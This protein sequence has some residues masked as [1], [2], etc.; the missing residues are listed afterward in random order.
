MEKLSVVI[1]TLNEERNIARCI[2]GVQQIADEVVVIDSNSTDATV[3]ICESLGARVIQQP[4]LGYTEQKNFA[5]EQA[6]FPFVFSIDADEVPDARL[7][8]SI[9]E[10]KDNPKANGYSM[11]RL[12]NYCGSWVR[13]CGWYPDRKLRI[14]YKDKGLWTGGALH[15]KYELNSKEES[16]LLKGDLLHYSYYSVDDHIKQVDKFTAISSKE[17]S[18]RGYNPSILKLISAAP[19]K[20]FRDYIL[21]LG[22]LD[23]YTGYQISKI[24]A[25]ATYLKYARARD[26][27]RIKSGMNQPNMKI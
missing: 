10:V 24:S 27:N 17:L 26:L 15:E 5:V 22:F 19:V 14:F 8:Q 20:F 7:L 21:K 16:V 13:H 1:I 4:F 18:E 6:T 2:S 25:F 3:A 9:K 12:T 23:G 11:N